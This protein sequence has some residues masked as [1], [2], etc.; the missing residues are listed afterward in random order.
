MPFEHELKNAYIGG[1]YEYNFDFTTKSWADRIAEG[2][3][4]TTNCSISSSWLTSSSSWSSVYCD[5]NW[6]DTALTNSTILRAEFVWYKAA[7]WNTTQRN[8]WWSKA[9]GTNWTWMY[10]DGSVNQFSVG[11]T[12]YLNTTISSP[13]GT[14]TSTLT[15]DLLTWATTYATPNLW[16]WTYTVSSSDIDKM[17]QATRLRI[18]VS[19]NSYIRSVSLFVS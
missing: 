3:Q 18:A 12:Q 9:D 4:N 13:V 14:Y 19:S 6:L 17:R 7:T 8:F 1:V 11:W 10:W 15:M 5:V 2:W 16:T